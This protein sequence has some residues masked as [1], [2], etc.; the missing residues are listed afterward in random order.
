MSYQ[1]KTGVTARYIAGSVVR[2]RMGGK[3][4]RGWRTNLKLNQ[5]IVRRIG[6]MSI[7]A[8]CRS[9]W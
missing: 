9:C 4:T 1:L 3:S 2:M 7:S 5:E 8:V 6:E